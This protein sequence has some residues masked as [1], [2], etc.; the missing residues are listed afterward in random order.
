MISVFGG[1]LE[2][3]PVALWL[4]EHEDTI[5]SMVVGLSQC[6]IPQADIFSEPIA[7]SAS[8]DRGSQLAT[9][10]HSLENLDSHRDG[11]R[12]NSGTSTKYRATSPDREIVS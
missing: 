8:S 9:I 12:R 3:A 6:R 4:H 7:L 1:C 11:Q 2:D 5:R 10:L